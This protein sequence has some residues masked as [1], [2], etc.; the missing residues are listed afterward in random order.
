[1][2]E[3]A[4]AARTTTAAALA[5]ALYAGFRF[6]ECLGTDLV[7][8]REPAA[9]ALAYLHVLNPKRTPA[10][11]ILVALSLVLGLLALRSA[12]PRRL[13]ALGLGLLLVEDGLTALHVPLVRLLARTTPDVAA[14]E[15]AWLRARYLF[16]D[17]AR[18]ALLVGAAIA[19]IAAG[20]RNRELERLAHTEER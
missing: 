7:L 19:Y 10:V 20:M 4:R 17:V 5:A 15:W 11:S 2:R 6:N 14:A 16:D 13:A 9:V 18:T 1:M 8:S 12:R 3:R